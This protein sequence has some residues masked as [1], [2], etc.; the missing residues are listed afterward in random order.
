MSNGSGAAHRDRPAAFRIAYPVTG[1]TTSYATCPP[2]GQNAMAAHTPAA[3]R[4]TIRPSGDLVEA[5]NTTAA[6]TATVPRSSCGGARPNKA[7]P[8]RFPASR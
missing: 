4:P 5:G 2:T 8:T 1:G 6:T 7:L 3:A